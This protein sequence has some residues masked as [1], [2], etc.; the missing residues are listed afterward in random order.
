MTGDATD[1]LGKSLYYI[2]LICQ[3]AESALSIVFFK[4]RSQSIV[5]SAIYDLNYNIYINNN[6]FINYY[7]YYQKLLSN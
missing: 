5:Y 6:A 2:G 7:H 3:L 1:M 4:W